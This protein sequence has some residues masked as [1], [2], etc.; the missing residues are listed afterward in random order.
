MQEEEALNRGGHVTETLG[1]IAIEAGS[2][3]SGGVSWVAGR[4]SGVGDGRS[5][6]DLSDELSGQI[7]AIAMLSSFNGP[8]P[9]WARGDGRGR[10]GFALSAEEDQSRDTE[11][12]HVGETV[13]YLAFGGAGTV[14]GYDDGLFG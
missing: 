6:V 7:N 4:V 12:T 14:Q 1:W 3:S 10:E 9:A 2:G 13:D 8:D 5:V 11:T